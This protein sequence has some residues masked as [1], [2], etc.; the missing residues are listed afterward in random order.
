[1]S[2]ELAWTLI[3]G[4]LTVVLTALTIREGW[5]KKEGR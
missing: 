5:M 1:M 4:T 3:V 2:L